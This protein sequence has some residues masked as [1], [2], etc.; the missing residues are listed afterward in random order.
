MIGNIPALFLVQLVTHAL[1]KFSKL[2]PGFG[3]VLVD[4]EVLE[5]PEPPTQ[6]LKP[7]A[8]FGETSDLCADLWGY[9]NK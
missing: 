8:L 3:V 7:L 2:S 9:E 5:M 6:V 1:A 4:D